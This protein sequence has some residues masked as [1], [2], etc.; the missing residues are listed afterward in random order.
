[1]VQ[2][3]TGFLKGSFRIESYDYLIG[4][5]QQGSALFEHRLDDAADGLGH[6]PEPG[7]EGGCVQIG[8]RRN[9]IKGISPQLLPFFRGGGCR[10][11]T[12]AL[13]RTTVEVRRRFNGYQLSAG[14]KLY[15]APPVIVTVGRLRRCVWRAL[16]R[17]LGINLACQKTQAQQEPDPYNLDW[18]HYL[19]SITQ[20]FARQT[21]LWQNHRHR[22]EN[23][24]IN[25]NIK[26]LKTALAYRPLTPVDKQGFGLP[27]FWIRAGAIFEL[28]IVG[29][30]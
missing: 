3:R 9:G 14:L 30:C 27:G 26:R 5:N 7:L 12:V 17:A 29:D 8:L 1:M 16:V 18:L 13:E 24:E 19:L 23:V 25:C 21:W 15:Q 11:C 28:D 10:D 20:V 22:R 4:G 6:G 2:E